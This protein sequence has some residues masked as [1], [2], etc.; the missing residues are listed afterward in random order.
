MSRDFLHSYFHV[1][2]QPCA[3]ATPQPMPITLASPMS[4]PLTTPL[5]TRAIPRT[6]SPH[7]GT[8]TS[9]YTARSLALPC[10]R[11][12]GQPCAPACALPLTTSRLLPMPRPFATRSPLRWTPSPVLTPFTPPMKTPVPRH[13]SGH[14]SYLPSLIPIS[15]PMSTWTGFA[16]RNRTLMLAMNSGQNMT[17]GRLSPA[18]YLSVAYPG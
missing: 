9:L 17:T 16:E 15:T 7:N 4:P 13:F 18:E 3:P 14:R 12:Y 2:D 11:A 6:D 8:N 1:Y 5:Q 10:P